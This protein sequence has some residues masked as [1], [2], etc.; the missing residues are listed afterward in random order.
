MDE[1][2]KQADYQ[3][4]KDDVEMQRQRARDASKDAHCNLSVAGAINEKRLPVAA[5][6]GKYPQ[7]VVGMQK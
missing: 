5:D 7:E 6:R 2:I 1:G 4:I 3:I